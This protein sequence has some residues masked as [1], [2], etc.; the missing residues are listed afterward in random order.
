MTNKKFSQGKFFGACCEEADVDAVMLEIKAVLAE[1]R[2]RQ[3]R[4]QEAEEEG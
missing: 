4:A 2:E 3:E 1:E